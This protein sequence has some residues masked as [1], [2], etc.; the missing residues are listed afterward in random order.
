MSLNQIQLDLEQQGDLQPDPSA[1]QKLKHRFLTWWNKDKN[2]LSLDE[3]Y[4]TLPI[5]TQEQIAHS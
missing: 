4:S 3:L 2:K 5:Q 1:C